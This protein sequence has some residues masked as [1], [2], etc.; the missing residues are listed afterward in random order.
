MIHG[1][2]I[3]ALTVTYLIIKHGSLE[4]LPSE[5]IFP[6]KPPFEFGDFP[7]VTMFFLFKCPFNEGFSTLPC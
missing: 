4:N 7:H 5:M 2:M 6:L 1:A 3:F